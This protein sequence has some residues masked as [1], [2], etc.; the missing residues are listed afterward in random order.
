MPTP[1]VDMFVGD[2]TKGPGEARHANRSLYEKAI[3][4]R[5][6]PSELDLQSELLKY[7]GILYT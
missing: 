3:T 4:F 7:T 6:G 2:S 1:A 5:R